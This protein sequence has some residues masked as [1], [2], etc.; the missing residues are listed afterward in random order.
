MN[1]RKSE[2][3]YVAEILTSSR[4]AL[5][6]I[7]VCSILYPLII[8]GLGQALVPDTAN[9]SLIRNGEGRIVGS[10]EIAQKFERPEYFWPRPSAVNY[11]ASASGGSNLSPANPKMRDR[12]EALLARFGGSVGQLIPADLVT[13]SGS[14]MDPNI[15]LQAAE[16][17]TPRVAEA[18]GVQISTVTNLLADHTRRPGGALTPEPLINVLV[19]NIALDSLSR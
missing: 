3:G 18:R 14:G 9:G 8:L 2:S 5:T 1:N 16:F 17:Q 15:S 11:D 19:V 4:I 10:K 7:A 12:A 13:A 6:T